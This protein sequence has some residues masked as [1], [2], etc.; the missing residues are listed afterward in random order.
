MCNSFTAAKIHKFFI[1]YLNRRGLK[2][3]FT[4]N[5]I[6]NSIAKR[7]FFIIFATWKI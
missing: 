3:R 2:E 1:S 7:A 6:D 5:F 4:H